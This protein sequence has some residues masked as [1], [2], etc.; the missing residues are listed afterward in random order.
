MQH[1]TERQAIRGSHHGSLSRVG[2]R[3]G[4]RAEKDTIEFFGIWHMEVHQLVGRRLKEWPEEALRYR[5]S[6][7][8]NSAA[9]LIWHIARCEDVGVNRLVADPPRSSRKRVGR[10]A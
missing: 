7:A 3:A 6:P 2:M 1:T 4:R 8:I 9:W 10:S 5:P